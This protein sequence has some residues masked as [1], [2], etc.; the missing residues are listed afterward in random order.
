V[1]LG[2]KTGCIN[3]EEKSGGEVNKECDYYP[4]IF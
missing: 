1:F 4:E 2:G 3:K